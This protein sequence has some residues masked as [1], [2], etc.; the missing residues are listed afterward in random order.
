M[1]N[2]A[3]PLCTHFY[4]LL[5]NFVVCAF[6]LAYISLISLFSFSSCIHEYH[7]NQKD[8]QI[9]ISSLVDMRENVLDST[10]NSKAEEMKTGP[11]KS[12]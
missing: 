1:S 2:C 5:K 11:G 3:I 9:P 10:C 8:M 12:H 7:D 6:M 4:S